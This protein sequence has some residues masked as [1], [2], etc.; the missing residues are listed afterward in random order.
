MA[1]SN[2]SG[3]PRIGPN[4]EL[5]FA[6]EGYWRGE[7]SAEQLAQTASEIRRANWKLMQDAGIDRE[8]LVFAQAV[9]GELGQADRDLGGALVEVLRHDAEGLAGVAHRDR[10]RADLGV[11]FEHTAQP[12]RLGQPFFHTGQPVAERRPPGAVVDR[13]VR[14]RWGRLR[15]LYARGSAR[16]DLGSGHA[17]QIGQPRR[18]RKGGPHQVRPFCYPSATGRSGP[19]ATQSSTAVASSSAVGNGCSGASR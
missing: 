6:A 4:R 15:D 18:L 13:M 3:F 12:P 9:A 17:T 2:I 5:K 16:G 1:L 7:T 10:R 19:A 8:R 14:V 11:V